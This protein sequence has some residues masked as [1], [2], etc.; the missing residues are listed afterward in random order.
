MRH[1]FHGLGGGSMPLMLSMASILIGSR[2]RWTLT[3]LPMLLVMVLFGMGCGGPPAAASNEVFTPTEAFGPQGPEMVAQQP[4][5]N[6]VLASRILTSQERAQVVSA[7]ASVVSG[8]V[9]PLTQAT[10]GIRFSDVP[11]AAV[12]AASEIEMA[13]VTTRHLWPEVQVRYADHEGFQATMTITLQKPLATVEVAYMVPNTSANL[14]AARMRNAMAQILWR[15]DAITSDTVQAAAREVVLS[16]G[17]TVL[18]ATDVPERYEIDLL[19]LDSQPAGLE[20][21]RLQGSKVME[22]HAWAGVFP[23][24]EV[25]EKLG[26]AF[27]DALR[28]WGRVPGLAQDE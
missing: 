4:A 26:R 5:L 2:S 8:K 9:Q 17:A 7:L 23:R 15:M 25:A 10:Y 28:A 18:D 1:V 16:A 14:P 21:T 13:V 6:D 12:T 27:E 20:V 24:K 22:W 3:I 19:M 11:R